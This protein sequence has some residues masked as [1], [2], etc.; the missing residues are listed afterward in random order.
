M[1]RTNAR[2]LML[3]LGCSVL[4]SSGAFAAEVSSIY[5]IHDAS[6]RP[7]EYLNR[8]KAAVGG[9]WVTATEEIGHDPSNT[10]GGDFSWFANEGHSVI[11]RLNNGYSNVGTIPLS[12][13]YDNFAT[14]CANY[15]QNSSGCEIWLIG[16]ETNLAYEWPPNAGHRSY[17]S[18]QDYA[19]CFR[20][21]YNAI[22]A[23]RPNHKVICQA[24]APFAGPF[25]SGT[26][27]DGT[28]HDGN[29]LNWVTYMNQMLTAIK[30]TGGLDGIAVHIN[31]RGYAYSDVHSTQ[32]I[33]AGGQ[34]LYW[35]F[36][37][38]KDW[39]N[40]GTPSDL[41]HLPFYATE[42]NGIYYWKGGHPEN[43][44]SHYETDW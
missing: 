2:V 37:V 36:F 39:V 11:C 8:I 42:C 13:Q 27:W 20:K 4:L 21:C 33:N 19:Q 23:V 34:M 10:N 18:P 28:T 44:S 38:Y 6:P 17:V 25:G 16:N 5:G 41:W 24:L 35:S 30:S 9:G 32:Q 12:S 3:F 26:L 31:S 29:P 43:P 40:L 1:L 15:V 22:K 14:R 7:T